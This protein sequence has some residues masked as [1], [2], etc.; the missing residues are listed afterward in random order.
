MVTNGVTDVERFTYAQWR[1]FAAYIEFTDE[2]E[3]HPQHRRTDPTELEKDR[4]MG[5]PDEQS[6]SEIRTVIEGLKEA[7]TTG[8]VDRYVGFFTD[9]IVA[10]PPRMS[11]VVGI[12]DWTKMCAMFARS[13]KSDV[14]WLTKNITVT[15]DMAIEWHVE[16]TTATDNETGESKRNYSKGVWIYRRENGQWKIAQYC[17]NASPEGEPE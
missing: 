3:Y 6:V 13:S 2:L 14:V 9:D 12:E 15:G 17:W 4:L 8:D 11:P 10:M 7:Y 16:A 1:L 5:I